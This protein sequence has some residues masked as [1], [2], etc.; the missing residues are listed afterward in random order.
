MTRA[1]ASVTGGYTR[2]TVSLPA[3]LVVKIDGYLK[4][5]P[6][7]TMSAFLTA[8]AEGHLETCLPRKK[9]H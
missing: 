3:A 2:K 9:K 8:A 6:G 1:R 7:L 4:K 5:T